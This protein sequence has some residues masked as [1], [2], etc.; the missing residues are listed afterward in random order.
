MEKTEKMLAAEKAFGIKYTEATEIADKLI[1]AY[2]DEEM[3]IEEVKKKSKKEGKEVETIINNFF[4][5]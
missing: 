3:T 5:K 4:K 1:D 2:Y